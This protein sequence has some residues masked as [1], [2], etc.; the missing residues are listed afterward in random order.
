MKRA[1]KRKYRFV[2]LDRVSF[3]FGETQE[4]PQIHWILTFEG[5]IDFPRLK[6]AVRL[7]LDAEPILGCRLIYDPIIPW[8]ERRRDL[9]DLENCRLVQT[10]DVERSINAFLTTPLDPF[11]DPQIQLCVF[12]KSED[13]L[14]VNINHMIMD[15]GG[16]K[17]YLHLLADL[18]NRLREDPDFK[19]AANLAGTRSLR[20]VSRQFTLLQK[21]KV[22]R[23]SLRDLKSDSFHLL[24]KI[25]L[26]TGRR[27]G[28]SN[29]VASDWGLPLKYGNMKD[30]TY[31]LRK[32]PAPVV[33]RLKE[34]ARSH[35]ATL[36]DAMLTAFYRAIHEQFA[37]H[38]EESMRVRATAD[39]RRYLPG[40]RGE[41]LCNLTNYVHVNLGRCLGTSF[42][43]TLV[44]VRDR[45]LSLKADFIGL[46]D[47]PI[48]VAFKFIPFWFTQELA[49]L[50]SMHWK[51]AKPV[52]TY[53][54]V[55]E[56]R[57]DLLHFDGLPIINACLTGPITYAPAF[58]LGITGFKGTLTLNAGITN[59][60]QNGPI[61][62]RL[63]DGMEKEI[64]SV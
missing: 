32:I 7:S 4:D 37:P 59:A 47:L 30:R 60:A 5:R 12:R 29:P 54:N 62:N 52:P 18:Y 61:L 35:G 56:L 9:D 26:K 14:V 3:Y 34:Y 58:I 23:R 33:R 41:A 28:A 50:D 39:L 20:Q 10:E 24:E 11:V 1:F 22:V 16:G 51:N 44:R 40:N 36:N 57:S 19:P 42:P 8:W 46:G 48:S 6:R 55:G 49:R 38:P 17:E 15:A 45:M 64:F 43:E 25:H 2:F 13:I 27:K 63:F 53:S 31:I 21:A